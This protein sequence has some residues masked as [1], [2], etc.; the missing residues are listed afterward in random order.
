MRCQRRPCSRSAARAGILVS[1]SCTLFSPKCRRPAAKA[2]STAEA[3]WVLLTATRVTS[4]NARPLRAAAEAMRSRTC[5]TLAAI[6]RSE[7]MRETLPE[8]RVAGPAVQARPR[9][10][11]FIGSLGLQLERG[12]HGLGRGH[13]LL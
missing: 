10:D 9:D 2:S 6:V 11:V 3:G 13:V 8:T 7:L 1:A 4:S 5:P 12:Q